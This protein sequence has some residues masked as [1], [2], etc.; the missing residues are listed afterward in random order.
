MT[1]CHGDYAREKVCP[2]KEISIRSLDHEQ[3]NTT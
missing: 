2:S 1:P 3:K